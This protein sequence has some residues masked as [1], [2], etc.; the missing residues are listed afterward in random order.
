VILPLE[1]YVPGR[2]PRPPEGAYDA[3]KGVADPL[4]ASPAWQAGRHFFAAGYDWEAHEVWEAVWMACPPN[5]AEVRLVQALIQIA[6]AELKLAMDKPNAAT[7]LC[8]IARAHLSEA[9]LYGRDEVLGVDV[10]WLAD[11]IEQCR[12]RARF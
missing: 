10:Q 3:L 1:P 2:T 6:N 4:E 9:A 7:R 8:G 11:V 12:S 5:S